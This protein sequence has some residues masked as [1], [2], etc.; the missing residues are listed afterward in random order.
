MNAT[1]QRQVEELLAADEEAC[2]RH[3]RTLGLGFWLLPLAPAIW[4][5]WAV[6]G[7]ERRRA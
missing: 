5:L 2:Q 3:A 6:S 4:W 7:G 1:V